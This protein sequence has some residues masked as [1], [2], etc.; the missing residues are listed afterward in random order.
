MTTTING[1]TVTDLRKIAKCA[2]VSARK[3]GGQWIINTPCGEDVPQHYS[4]TTEREALARWLARDPI[5]VR[6][7]ETQTGIEVVRG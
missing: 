5:L 2:K 3:Q 6:V 4:I 1:L 7:V